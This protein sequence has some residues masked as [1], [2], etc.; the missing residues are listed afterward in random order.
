VDSALRSAWPDVAASRRRTLIGTVAVLA[1]L[2]VSGGLLA[3]SAVK[4]HSADAHAASV[5]AS[6]NG[7][8]VDMLD[9][10]TGQRG[11]LLTG[12][13]AY[14]APYQ[15]A[16]RRLPRAAAR[17]RSVDPVLASAPLDALIAAK[18][19]VIGRTIA[20]ERA[21]D[22]ER[23]VAIVAGGR[24]KRLMDAIRRAVTRVQRAA[25]AS[26]R[27]ER[28]SARLRVGGTWTAIAVLVLAL[29]LL[30]VRARRL[31]LVGTTAAENFHRVFEEAPI[32]M[33]LWPLSGAELG[34]FQQ[35]N[36]G[37]ALITG[38][39]RAVLLEMDV[40][41][42]THPLDRE[43]VKSTLA[44]LSG[45][46]APS[47]TTDRRWLHADGSLLWVSI[48]ASIVRES[49]GA[50]FCVMQ[51]VDITA[52]RE[53]EERLTRLAMFDPLT[54]LPNRTL[55][56]DHLT[57]ALA[58]AERHDRPVAV[59]Y[60]DID[61]FKEI[62]D[63]HGHS[64]GDA[65]LIEAAQR[66]RGCLRD[67]DTIARIGG[68][69]FVIVC[70]DVTADERRDIDALVQRLAESLAEPLQLIGTELG[71]EASIGVALAYGD[72]DPEELVH[73]ADA[74][75]Y[76]AKAGGKARHAIAD[77]ELVARAHRHV[78]LGQELR[79][80]I[81]HEEFVLHY[82]PVIDLRTRRIVSVEALLRWQHPERGLLS[83]GDFLDDA[84]ERSLIVPIGE[85]VLRSA[86]RQAA[87]W[88]A[89]FGHQAP[90]V[91]IN[92]AQRQLARHDLVD[93]VRG[94]LEESSLPPN[95]LTLEVTERQLLSVSNSGQA[96]LARLSESGVRL[97]IDDFGTGYSTFEYLRRF[98][99]DVLKIDRSFISRLGTDATDSA[100]VRALLALSDS[101][102]LSVIAEGVETE[103]QLQ[104]LAALGCPLAQGFHLH[105]PA[106]FETIDELLREATSPMAA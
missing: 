36:G 16:L 49:T 23:A 44:Q 48:T 65:V 88:F 52:R 63:L 60:L 90:A 38:Y 100:I 101:L 64:V 4:S 15:A 41:S 79:A 71:L 83:P 104:E 20:L 7:L 47:L 21:G 33:A 84:E 19:A 73:Q 29:C 53:A 76:H 31:R 40:L 34:H 89:D 13:S 75:M 6:S 43:L 77:T 14:L 57:R 95:R 8:L 99:F 61:N 22:H 69:E 105:R 91:A 85:W 1:L 39:P 51:I 86:C 3:V 66:L 106:G 2:V 17:L 18:L 25:N 68:D 28:A 55:M 42:L 32:G 103:R 70:E 35:V 45:P 46:I 94:A 9:V 67:S 56:Y 81:D 27:R 54:E 58:R 37:L 96:D 24:G 62:N 74:A 59:L 50:T 30:L 87:N 82:Q 98:E 72:R 93:R 10:E 92:V 11:F 97:A 80:A 102:H 5:V 78:L 12:R 26:A